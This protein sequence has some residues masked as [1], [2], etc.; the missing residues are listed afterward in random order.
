MAAFIPSRRDPEVNERA[1][2]KVR[3]DKTRESQ[4]GHDGTWVAHPDLVPLATEVFDLALGD[5]PNQI[6]VNRP[7]RDITAGDLLFSNPIPRISRAGV[8]QN[9]DVAIQYLASWLRGNGAAGINNLMEDAATAEISRSQIWQWIHHRALL[10][11]GTPITAD[12]VRATADTL[13]LR[14]RDQLGHDS[15]NAGR[16]DDARRLFETVAL[17]DHFP[18]FLTSAAYEYLEPIE[19][20]AGPSGR[21][22]RKE[23]A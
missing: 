22:R 12:L 4:A 5:R 23:D 9:V 8:E 13:C 11:D 10:D 6:N 15:Y 21:T 3:E 18:D 17:S 14:I 20:T 2:A 7:G 1:F 16:F 19:A